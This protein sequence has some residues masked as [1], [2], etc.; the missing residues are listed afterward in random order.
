MGVPLS[1]AVK[2]SIL[3]GQGEYKLLPLAEISQALPR[4]IPGDF[5][6]TSLTENSS[7]HHLHM[8]DG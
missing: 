3:A 2:Q 7:T 5:D 8:M 4:L 1:T 6:Q